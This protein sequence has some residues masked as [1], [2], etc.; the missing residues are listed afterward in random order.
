VR[1]RG[2]VLGY[3]HIGSAPRDARA[4]GE[5]VRVLAFLAFQLALAGAPSGVAVLDL[6][7]DPGVAEVKALR[8]AFSRAAAD[9]L[10][11]PPVSGNNLDGMVAL[12]GCVAPDE[13]CL[14]QVSASLGVRFL[15]YG[16]AR[17]DAGGFSL[18]LSLFDADRRGVAAT[19][20]APVASPKDAEGL[21]AALRA[22]LAVDAAAEIRS[23][24]AS[25]PPEPKVGEPPKKRRSVLRF[26]P[27]LALAVGAGVLGARALQKDGEVEAI[28]DQI[29]A[30]RDKPVPDG[31]LLESLSDDGGVLKRQRLTA[32]IASDALSLAAGLGLV[33]AFTF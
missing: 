16:R 21:A 24:A 7:A 20:T 12:Y 11:A 2:G 8:A 4:A 1:F 22:L 14:G 19:A 33:L 31:A 17:A 27:S 3:G 9:A 32:A 25:P 23:A 10:K 26:A 18:S 29:K 30:E 15:I 28:T 13:A 5:E 6:D